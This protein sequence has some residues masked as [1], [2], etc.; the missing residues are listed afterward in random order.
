MFLK[1]EKKAFDEKH[2]K[3]RSQTKGLVEYYL[4]E[5]SS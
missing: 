1:I 2:N 3:N 4:V 5:N